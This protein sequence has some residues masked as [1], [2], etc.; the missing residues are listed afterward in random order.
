[1]SARSLGTVK[2]PNPTENSLYLC[3]KSKPSDH[4]KWKTVTTSNGLSILSSAAVEGLSSC[5]G[6]LLLLFEPSLKTVLLRCLKQTS[7]NEWLCCEFATCDQ[8]FLLK[9]KYI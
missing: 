4:R 9:Y 5:A 1:M 7:I 3:K 2:K 6:L 8:K